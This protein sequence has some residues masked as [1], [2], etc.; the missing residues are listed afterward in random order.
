MKTFNGIVILV[1]LTFSCAKT[2]AH[3][4]HDHHEPITASKAKEIALYITGEFT[5]RDVGLPFGQLPTSWK[6][7]SQESAVIK[8][9][10]D[11][12]YIVAIENKAVE[13]TLFILMAAT[14][15]V[16]DASFVGD[17]PLL[18]K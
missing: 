3:G 17:F 6:S 16:Y 18:N 4:D 10:T 9:Q 11:E 8:E 12:Y 7:L 5:Q 15:E 1:L 13:K 2:I 14:G